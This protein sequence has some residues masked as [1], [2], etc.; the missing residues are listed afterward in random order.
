MERLRLIYKLEYDSVNHCYPC[1]L[2]DSNY[3]THLNLEEITENNIDEE[4]KNVGRRWGMDIEKKCEAGR[5]TRK[6]PV[7]A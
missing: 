7:R 4:V 3:N 2:Q 1:L 6:R 5:S